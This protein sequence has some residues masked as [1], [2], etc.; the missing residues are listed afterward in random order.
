VSKPSRKTLAEELEEAE[1]TIP[2]VGRAAERFDHLR[3]QYGFWKRA[4]ERRAT[5]GK[6]P[7]GP[8]ERAR[9]RGDQSIPASQ[10]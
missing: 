4:N 6:P 3:W 2:E 1:R 5:E 7:I 9:K 8:F 10:D